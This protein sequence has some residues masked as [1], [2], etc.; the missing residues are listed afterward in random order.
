MFKVLNYYLWMRY[1]FHSHDSNVVEDPKKRPRV[2]MVGWNADDSLLLTAASDHLVKVWNPKTGELIRTLQHH[3]EV[4]YVI[5][6]HPTNPRVICT[7]GHDGKTIIWDIG[8]TDFNDTGKIIFEHTNNLDEGQGFGA[9]FDCKWSPDG[10]SLAATDSHGHLLIFT[11]HSKEHSK[12][13]KLPKELFFHTD[14]RPVTRDAISH[15]ILDEQTQVPPHLM[16]PPFLVDMDGNPYPPELQRLVRG[17]EQCRDDQLI[18]TVAIA[19]GGNR[20]VIEGLI[21]GN[22][23]SNIDAMIE[24]L[25]IAQGVQDAANAEQG[26]RSCRLG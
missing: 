26:K 24:Q 1:V 6:A 14:Y 13:K 22:A 17:R 8:T 18:P 9:V 12:F 16:P 21:D 2:T 11:T 4:A 15:E 23:R 19:P 3:Q 25:A 20:E 7:A 10:L 5:E